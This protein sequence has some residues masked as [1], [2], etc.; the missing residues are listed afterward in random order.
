[1]TIDRNLLLE[2]IQ[3][4]YE[5][6]RNLEPVEA[7]RKAEWTRGG[8][9]NASMN[10][11]GGRGNEIPLPVSQTVT[12]RNPDGSPN[13][14]SAIVPADE[15]DRTIRRI[16]R[17]I[18]RSLLEVD[19]AWTAAYEAISWYLTAVGAQ[20]EPELPCGNLRCTGL[21]EAGRTAGSE[22]AKCRKHR[23]RHGIE[24]PLLP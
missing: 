16:D 5:L 19:R 7:R 15:V 13:R 1:M 8:H 24:W 4:K 23:S 21:L 22:C 20:T 2:S 11:G 18:E 6:F 12:G 10:D 9:R 3:H 17:T 14:W